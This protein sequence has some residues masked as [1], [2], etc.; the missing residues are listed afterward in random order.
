MKLR[1]SLPFSVLIS[2]P[3]REG[4]RSSM[5]RNVMLST[6]PLPI[7]PMFA[8]I[9][10]RIVTRS[11]R[12]LRVQPSFPFCCGCGHPGFMT[13]LSSPFSMNTSAMWTSCEP[14]PGSAPESKRT[15]VRKRPSVCWCHRVS[16]PMPSVLAG[17]HSRCSGRSCQTRPPPPQVPFLPTP[18]LVIGAVFCHSANMGDRATGS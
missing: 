3:A 14:A 10:R 11:T 2:T 18:P 1:L 17:S 15:S 8:P 12:T 16:L 9:P 6:Q 7:P 5:S 4:R 13:M